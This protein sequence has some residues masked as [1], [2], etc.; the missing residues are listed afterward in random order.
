M[1]GIRQVRQGGVC[2]ARPA[3]PR[4]R[5]NTPPPAHQTATPRG[6]LRPFNRWLLV[7]R[8]H[9]R[10]G[11][12]IPRAGDGG[13][14]MKDTARPEELQPL[15]AAEF[16]AEKAFDQDRPPVSAVQD[17]GTADKPR[18]GGG[19]AAPGG[20]A[21]ASPSTAGATRAQPFRCGRGCQ[22]RWE[23]GARSRDMGRPPLPRSPAQT[24]RRGPIPRPAP[25][26]PPTPR[27]RTKPP[28]PWLCG[29]PA[30]PASP[31]RRCSSASPCWG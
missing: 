16:D 10:K 14:A 11:P 25:R 12:L 28:A 6:G 30:P 4:R 18:H 24:R 7:D 29:T 15:R 5:L 8:T 1:G 21:P 13:A 23:V 27:A 20:A 22:A 31:S 2:D 9:P 19:G 17:A 26:P 3:A